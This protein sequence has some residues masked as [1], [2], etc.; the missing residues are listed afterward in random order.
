MIARTMGEVLTAAATRAPD[1]L[2]FFDDKTQLTFRETEEQANQLAHLLIAE[3]VRKGDRVAVFMPRVLD[4][5]IALYAV[6]KAGAVAVPIDSGVPPPR[7]RAILNNCDVKVMITR[8]QETPAVNAILREAASIATVIGPDSL[9]TEHRCTPLSHARG[10][11]TAAPKVP[12]EPKDNAYI[13]HT[14]G[15][16]G[17][18]KGI[19]HTHASGFAFT[20]LIS[21]HLAL[22]PEDRIACPFMLQFDFSLVAYFGGP[23]S[24]AS[25]L[26]VPAAY[27]SLPASLSSLLA[28][29]RATVFVAVSSGL[30]QLIE[31]GIQPTH[32]LT[33]LRIVG[34]GGEP[35]LPSSLR[36]GM[37][38]LDRTDFVNLY[39]PTETNACLT[40][41]F[42]ASETD[43][44]QITAIPI[45]K[46]WDRTQALVLDENLEDVPH[47]EVGE[48]C[49]T[50]VTNMTGYWK[51]DDLNAQAFLERDG[52]SYYRTGDLVWQDETGRYWLVG[53]KDRQIK[54]HGYRIELDE[55]E[56]ALGSH[57]HV[58]SVGA[59]PLRKDNVVTAIAASVQLRPGAPE[60][61]TSEILRHASQI[62]PRYAVPTQIDVK[63]VLPLTV[64]GKVDRK[65][66]ETEAM[67]D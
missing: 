9:E 30:S 17:T 62:L 3:G 55:V 54:L 67:K 52:L 5:A 39:G 36:Q 27:T 29:S 31:M 22:R 63:P 56:S 16:T 61:K 15:S 66:L 12:V 20:E 34:F 42:T 45:G 10:F 64:T 46:T 21:A 59:Y 41:W 32:D 8:A 13:L 57:P 44:G 35:L 65:A 19:V 51:R 1:D 60:T 23:F 18:P 33:A 14:S 7:V 28:S 48:L 53:R 47:G 11:P 26:I 50:S 25:A 37:S 40:H 6:F 43:V 2:A 38:R 49:I 58:L 4:G 24:G